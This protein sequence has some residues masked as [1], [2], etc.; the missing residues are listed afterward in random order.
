MNAHQL[1][2]SILS[3]V[4]ERWRR[5]AMVVGCV[6]DTHGIPLQAGDGGLK[7]IAARIEALVAD[8]RLIAQGDL[9]K[10]RYSEVRK[11]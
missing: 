10:W 8:G 3:E 7:L 6:A 4:G 9:K 11:P 2:Q 5:V 1:D